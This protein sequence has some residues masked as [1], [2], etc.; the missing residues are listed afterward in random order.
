MRQLVVI[1]LAHLTLFLN[2]IMAN[3]FVTIQYSKNSAYI[4]TVRK[5]VDNT[6]AELVVGCK[7]CDFAK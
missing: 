3:C 1:F 4:Y 7:D 6:G 5:V 2:A